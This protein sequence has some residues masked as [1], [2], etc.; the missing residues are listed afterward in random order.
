MRSMRIAVA[1][2]SR[3][4][5][6]VIR[7]MSTSHKGVDAP[8]FGGVHH[9]HTFVNKRHTTHAYI[10][11]FIYICVCVCMCVCVYT[12]VCVCIHIYA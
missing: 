1:L 5:L 7:H 2:K 6:L 9:A 12:C 3:G 10:Y 11:T 4:P 8:N